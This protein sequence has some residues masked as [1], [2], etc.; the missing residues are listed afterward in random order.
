MSGPVW[1]KYS[2]L[3]KV[4]VVTGFSGQARVPKMEW[5]SGGLIIS[6]KQVVLGYETS[7]NICKTYRLISSPA[8]MLLPFLSFSLEEN[9]TN[10]VELI[11]LSALTQDSDRLKILVHPLL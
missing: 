6:C 7:E 2:Q 1:G 10:F 9:V 3:N 4:T 5:R 11:S 8:S